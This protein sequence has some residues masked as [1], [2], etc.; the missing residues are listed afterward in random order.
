MKIE[1][2]NKEIFQCKNKIQVLE[3]KLEA[4]KRE[5]GTQNSR[6]NRVNQRE[7]NAF[8]G[9]DF[10]R[11]FFEEQGFPNMFNEDEFPFPE[12]NMGLR[13]TRQRNHSNHANQRRGIIG[14]ED[15]G[16]YIPDDMLLFPGEE[17]SNLEQQIINQ[18]CPNPDNMSYEEL[19]KLEQ[20]MGSVS[21]GLNQNAIRRIPLV[22]YSKNQFK[23][24]DKC[25]ICQED[26]KT[27]EKVSKLS[28]NH[29]YHPECIK[30][31]LKSNKKCPF[32]MQE[33]QM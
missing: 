24:N 9:N 17:E 3:K 5:V 1:N 16:E 22:S 6:V 15:F 7:N 12:M 8:G 20:D 4:L 18:L 25:V 11:N 27:G 19:L 2:K 21:K 30:E 23:D 32:C 13:P 33:I 28:C 14:A 10:F 31:W 29:I 26:F